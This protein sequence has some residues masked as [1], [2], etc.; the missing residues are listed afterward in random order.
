MYSKTTWTTAIRRPLTA[1]E[2]EWV[3]GIEDKMAGTH[4]VQIKGGKVLLICRHKL[5]DERHLGV[6]DKNVET[7]KVWLYGER[8]KC[9]QNRAAEQM[10]VRGI[11]SAKVRLRRAYQT[12]KGDKGIQDDRRHHDMPDKAVEEEAERK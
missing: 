10:R 2:M 7:D 5:N 4:S 12:S 3:S 8:D 11:G 6:T 1:T 9:G